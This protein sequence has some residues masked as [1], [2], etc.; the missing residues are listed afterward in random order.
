MARVFNDQYKSRSPSRAGS[1]N[2]CLL[3]PPPVITTYLLGGHFG[4]IDWCL[5]TNLNELTMP[6]LRIDAPVSEINNNNSENNN[7]GRHRWLRKDQ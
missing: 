5:L 2:K 4:L 1:M 3:M 7:I 6:S